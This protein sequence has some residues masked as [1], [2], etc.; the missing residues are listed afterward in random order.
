MKYQTD[1]VDIHIHHSCNLAC[2]GC[3][4]FSDLTK[5]EE[6]KDKN[7]LDDLNKVTKKVKITKQ[8][9]ILG[10]EPLYRKNFKELFISA[11]RVLQKNNFNLKF[12]VLYTN[13][14]LLNKNLYLKTLLTN[15]KFR[16]N[17]TFHPTKKSKLYITLKRNL[18]N[19]F[20]NW[21]S[22][23]QVTIYDPLRWQ[24][25]YLEYKGKIFP[26]LSQDIEA[27]YKHCVCPNVQVLDGKLYKCAPIAYLPFALKKTKQLNA[28]YW[29]PYLNYVPADLDND[30]ELDVF[31]S[32]HKK[33]EKIC[34]MCPSS[35]KFF[36]KYDR[37]IK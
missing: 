9:S 35:P 14:L 5:D 19:T 30:D 27:S 31:F 16:L 29:K 7:F 10:G 32:K 20:K 2:A 34:S 4:H 3:N 24:K 23:K 12:L 25:T 13:G 17:I 1:I 22:F 36:E 21:K 26:H 6:R 33:A 11:L 28:S 15:Y 37:R 18:Y 8:L